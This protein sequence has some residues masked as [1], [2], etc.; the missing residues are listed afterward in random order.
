[1]LISKYV[2]CNDF[3]EVKKINIKYDC[4][5]LKLLKI[6]HRNRHKKLHLL[7]CVAGKEMSIQLIRPLYNIATIN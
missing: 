4:G 3:C 7:I 2:M 1:M 6:S 5:V